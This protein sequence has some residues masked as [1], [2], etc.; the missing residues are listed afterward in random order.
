[1]TKIQEWCQPHWDELRQAIEAKRLS[2][3]VSRGGVAAAAMMADELAVGAARDAEGFD[4][5]LRAWSMINGRALEM[6]SGLVGCPLCFVQRHHDECDQPNCAKP[7]PSEWIVGCADSLREY[8][9][10]LGLLS[11]KRPE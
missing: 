3:L 8:A 4:P 2:H 10:T 1:M 7:L 5:L 11:E 9:N 6:G